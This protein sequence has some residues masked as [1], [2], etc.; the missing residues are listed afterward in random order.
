MSVLDRASDRSGKQWVYVGSSE[1]NKPIGWVYRDFIVCP[2][3]QTRAEGGPSFNCAYAKAPDEVL[4]CQNKQLAAQDREMAGLYS[5][6]LNNFK[7]GFRAYLQQ[8]QD[9]WLKRRH[10][11]GY[12]AECIDEA[13]LQRL[14][15]FGDGDMMLSEFCRDHQTDIDCRIQSNGYDPV[16]PDARQR[17]R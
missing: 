2:A 3:T 9:A 15:Q 13:Y 6:G 5:W 17:G 8:S 11:C 4:I 16:P 1:D 14:A 12:D 10:A 7:G